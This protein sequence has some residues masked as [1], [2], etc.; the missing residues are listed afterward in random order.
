MDYYCKQGNEVDSETKE[1]MS[2]NQN[3]RFPKAA[4]PLKLKEGGYYMDDNV[5]IDIN[6]TSITEPIK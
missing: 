2:K 4:E 6:D 1:I 3:L 5:D